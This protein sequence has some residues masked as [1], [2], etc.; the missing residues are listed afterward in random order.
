M[1]RIGVAGHRWIAPEA[2]SVASVQCSAILQRARAHWG[3]VLALSATAEG[4]DA[5]FA[6]AAVSLGIPLE[7]VRPF[8][9][10]AADFTTRDARERYE[11]LRAAARLETRLAFDRRSIEAYVAGMQWI[12]E[13]SDILV[14][15][16]DGRAA[17]GAGGTAHAVDQANRAGRPWIHLNVM[18]GRV[19]GHVPRG[20]GP[21]T[22]ALDRLVR[23]SHGLL[24]S[25]GAVT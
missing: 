2:V 15:V 1:I 13:N 12:V 7:I 11:R 8:D 23:D 20:A 5:F 18:N 4:A 10:Y 16:W 21:A 19:S 9:E 22:H 3:A 24:A 14:A 25:S 6:E 17:L